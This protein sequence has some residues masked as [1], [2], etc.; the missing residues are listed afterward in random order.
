MRLLGWCQ[1]KH[2]GNANVESGGENAHD[3]RN[4][5]AHALRPGVQLK[6]PKRPWR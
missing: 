3:T 4:A 6:G 5:D 2:G 1:L